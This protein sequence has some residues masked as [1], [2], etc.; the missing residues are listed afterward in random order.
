MGF[1]KQ[2][3]VFLAAHFHRYELVPFMDKG[4]IYYRADCQYDFCDSLPQ[5]WVNYK[6]G[7]KYIIYSWG[8]HDQMK[9][10][11]LDNYLF[12]NQAIQL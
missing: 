1:I 2:S 7:C 10:N 6:S 5:A 4:L 8:V 11:K 9:S 12:D 3:L